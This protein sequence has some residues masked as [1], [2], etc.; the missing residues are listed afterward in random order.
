MFKNDK[1]IETLNKFNI[2]TTDEFEQRLF[3]TT[4]ERK[5]DTFDNEN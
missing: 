4:V 1:R 5:R 2:E 3:N